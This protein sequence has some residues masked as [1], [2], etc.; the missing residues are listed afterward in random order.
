MHGLYIPLLILNKITSGTSTPPPPPPL[1]TREFLNILK[2]IQA[3][4]GN[5]N[6]RSV[7]LT[8][9]SICFL[10]GSLH[11]HMREIVLQ[12]SA[13]AAFYAWLQMIHEII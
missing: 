1:P 8:V 4:Q 10:V 11:N 13:N 12:N 6:L 2:C 3:D 7:I 9:W 5:D